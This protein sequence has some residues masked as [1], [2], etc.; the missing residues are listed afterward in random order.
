MNTASESGVRGSAG[1]FTS[2]T[3]ARGAGVQGARGNNVGAVRASGGNVYA[4]ADGNVYR[5]TDSGWS[6]WDNGQWN[7]VQR[8]N[9][10]TA[11]SQ[12]RRQQPRSLGGTQ[13]A[14]R[15]PAQSDPQF[16]QLDQD[17]Q[18][19]Q[20]SQQRNF[21]GR[22]FGGAGGRDLGGSGFRERGFR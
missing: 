17:R 8:P 12:A 13:Q 9:Q 14:F 3:G 22:N 20:F 16:R 15:R 2:S 18:A 11:A 4:G 5:H 19:R 1:A 6:K 7:Q 10:N 21:G